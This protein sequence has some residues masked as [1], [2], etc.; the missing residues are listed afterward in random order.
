MSNSDDEN[1]APLVNKQESPKEF[2]FP[3]G[4][5]ECSMCNNYNFQLRQNCFRCKKE[6]DETDFAGKPKH[7]RKAENKR[8]KIKLLGLNGEQ[9]P[10]P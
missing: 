7:I 2:T 1:E 9:A 6:R 4:G 3:D 10:R 5:W 8:A